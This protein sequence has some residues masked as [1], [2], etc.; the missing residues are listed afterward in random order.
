MSSSKI[1]I[2]QP[3][4]L[5]VVVGR[6][7]T[8]WRA[9]RRGSTARSAED[10]RRFGVLNAAM[11]DSFF[12]TRKRPSA[13]RFSLNRGAIDCRRVARGKQLPRLLRERH[14][15]VPDDHHADIVKI[16][17]GEVGGVALLFRS[18]RD[19]CCIERGH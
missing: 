4:A 2:V 13:D 8:A 17:I 18:R 1:R 6:R 15:V 16:V 9:S 11:S 12:V 3:R 7:P 5:V 19:I 14:H 10:W